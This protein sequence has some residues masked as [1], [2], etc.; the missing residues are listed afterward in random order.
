MSEDNVIST[1]FLIDIQRGKVPGASFYGDMSISTAFGDFKIG[2]DAAVG[3]EGFARLS[4]GGLAPKIRNEVIRRANS[5]SS[6]GNISFD[7]ASQ[8]VMI[9]SNIDKIEDM[10]KIAIAVDIPELA[11]EKILGNIE[12]ILN[13]PNFDKVAYLASAVDSVINMFQT[14]GQAS[15]YAK[16]SQSS[17]PLDLLSSMLGSFGGGGGIQRMIDVGATEDKVGHFL[18]ELL[19]GKRIPSTVI[20]CNPMKESPSYQGKVFFGEASAPISLVDMNEIFNRKIGAYGNPMNG[21]GTSSFNFT[22]MG[23]LQ[24]SFNLGDMVKKFTFGGGNPASAKVT[25]VIEKATTIMGANPLDS[26]EFNRADNAIPFMI[27]M[28]AINTGLE[29]SPFSTTTFSEGWKL[30]QSVNSFLATDQNDFLTVIRKLG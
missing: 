17:N 22:N 2:V 18:S 10:T 28:S 24:G 30:A 14:F 23:S 4:I 1:D 19:S 20:A 11:D 25:E 26:I 6:F 8:F 29:K 27:G 7:T 15:G 12:A 16:A 5:M 3:Y 21:S 9:L 13:V